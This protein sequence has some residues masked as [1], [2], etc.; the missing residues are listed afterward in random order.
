M[1]SNLHTEEL[2]ASYAALIL[3]DGQI[4]VTAENIVALAKAAGIN[5]Q[6]IWPRLFQEVFSTRSVGDFLTTGV[7]AGAPSGGAAPAAA[8]AASAAAPEKE[9][10]K[11]EV[12]KEESDEDM[13]FGLFD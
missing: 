5:I 4:P 11:E 1:P 7:G 8:P 3:H 10:E 12:K 9:K 6:P 13:G 2:A